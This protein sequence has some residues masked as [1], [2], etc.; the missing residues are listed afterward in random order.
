MLDV[1]YTD[2]RPM[3]TPSQNIFRC[4]S[5]IVLAGD[6][7]QFVSL[8]YEVSKLTAINRN[9]MFLTCPISSSVLDVDLE[10]VSDELMAIG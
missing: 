9:V 1:R 4:N 2:S 7:F 8:P 6:N 3:S 10:T 5:T